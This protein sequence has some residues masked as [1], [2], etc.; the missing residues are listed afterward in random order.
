MSIVII[1]QE[2]CSHERFNE[3]AKLNA[4]HVSVILQIQQYKTE[5]N[6]II[7]QNKDFTPQFPY[8]Y[9]LTGSELYHLW[10][11]EDQ[12]TLSVPVFKVYKHMMDLIQYYMEECHEH[13]VCV[14]QWDCEDDNYGYQS[15]QVVYTDKTWNCR[16][17]FVSPTKVANRAKFSNVLK[18][19]C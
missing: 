16:Y 8:I 12:K 2:K 7:T 4:M 15:F 9:H 11:R 18:Y 13:Q 6:D 1:H 17:L 14:A 5:F 19:P 3:W 10:D